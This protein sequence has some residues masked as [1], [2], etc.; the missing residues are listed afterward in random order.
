ML[1]QI[2]PSRRSGPRL[3]FL[4]M[5]AATEALSS[6]YL[7]DIFATSSLLKLGSPCFV[8]KACKVLL[9]SYHHERD[10]ILESFLLEPDEVGVDVSH[11]FNIFFFLRRGEH[12]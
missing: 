1:R 10:L 8:R 5:R 7:T 4:S 12:N 3:R 2:N 11:V 9:S 6:M